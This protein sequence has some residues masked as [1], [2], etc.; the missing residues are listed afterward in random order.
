MSASV[1]GSEHF[2]LHIKPATFTAQ[3]RELITRT[4]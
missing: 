4:R 2:G 1:V 3:V